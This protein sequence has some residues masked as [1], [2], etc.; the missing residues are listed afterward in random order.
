MTT[1]HSI[2]ASTAA[3]HPIAVCSRAY[4]PHNFANAFFFVGARQGRADHGCSPA[5]VTL[6]TIHPTL[7][8]PIAT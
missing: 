1:R 4:A 8:H 5:R 7:F 3:V 6:P 2:A